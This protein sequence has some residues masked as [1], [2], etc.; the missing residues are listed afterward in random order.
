MKNLTNTFYVVKFIKKTITTKGINMAGNKTLNKAKE[1]QQDEYYTRLEDI[2]AELKHY[3]KHFKDSVVL[4]NCD[5]PYESNFFKYFALNFNKLGLKKLIC[6][7]YKGSPVIATQLSFI[8]GI[9][10]SIALN[11]KTNK[12]AYKIVITEVPDVTGDGAIDI[13]DVEWLIKNDKNV[14]T[15]LKGDGSYDSS[16]CKEL[17]LESDICVT[18]PPFSRFNDF[19]IFLVNSGKK[20]LVLGNPNA[21]HY[22][23]IFPQ[24]KNNKIWIGYKSMGTDML[25]H[26]PKDF[27]EHLVKT[28]K[29]GS[30][31]RIVNGEVLGRAMAIWF[32]NLDIKKRHEKLDLYK[33][34]NPK[35]Y[36]KY[37]NYDAIDV[38]KVS[39]IPK[40]YYGD[41]GVPDSFITQ[42]NPEQF[43]LIGIGSGNLAKEI[44]VIKNY[45]GRTDLA[46][47]ENG[48]YKC[49]Y[50]RIIIKREGAE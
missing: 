18:N 36:P 42:Y 26:V 23:D 3:R 32:T 27:A 14:L 2:S 11:R 35:E 21:M 44:G 49:P 16:E 28:K 17:L 39:E 13:A 25:F 19:L 45:R 20:F 46:I 38:G 29:E 9:E 7:C 6:T 47:N 12:K 5:D 31:Y 22:R 10:A 33:K 40:D 34:Y 43:K 37:C 50:S 4:C 8:D 41:M 15:E 30:G 1:A 24:I 48:K